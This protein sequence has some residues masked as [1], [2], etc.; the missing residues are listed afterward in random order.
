MDTLGIDYGDEEIDLMMTEIDEDK[1]GEIVRLPVALSLHAHPSPCSECVVPCSR[2]TL[3]VSQRPS[4]SLRMQCYP[5]LLLPLP[6]SWV[7]SNVATSCICALRR[8]ATQTQCHCFDPQP[9]V[10]VQA[11]S[12]R[13]TIL[14]VPLLSFPFTYIT[15]PS[16]APSHSSQSYSRRSLAKDFYEFVAVMSKKLGSDFEKKK[17]LDAFGMLRVE[18]TDDP[19]AVSVD[20]V[21]NALMHDGTKAMT[22]EQA[23]E[24]VAQMN[25]QGGKINFEAFVGLMME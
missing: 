3:S 23:N 2:Q 11:H 4:T 6:W 9:R 1:D 18:S 13:C 10:H 15:R 8:H 20:M 7:A 21:M 25:P 17:V 22:R 19:G 16:D 12:F 5:L 14:E 24:L